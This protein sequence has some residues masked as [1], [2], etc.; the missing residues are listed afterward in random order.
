MEEIPRKVIVRAPARLHFGFLDL[1]GDVGRIY[2]SV[3]VAI[4]S[5]NVVLEASLD[6]KLNVTGEGK[7]TVAGYARSFLKKFDVGQGAR[8]Q[9]KSS[10]PRHAGLGS[11]TQLALATGLALSKLYNVRTSVEDLSL[12]M[13]R[14]VVSAIGIYAFK[15][16]GFIVEGGHKVGETKAVPPLLF[17]HDFPKNWLFVVGVPSI[18]RGPGEREETKHFVKPPLMSKEDVCE[19]SRVVLMRLLPA[20]LEK[21]V[22]SFG[23][24]ITELDS[25]VGDYWKPVQGGRFCDPVV[26]RGVE[27]LLDSGAYG[28]GQSSWGP[29]FYGLVRGE[30]E[31]IEL[32]QVLQRFLFEEGGGTAFH[33][34]ANNSGATA[35]VEGQLVK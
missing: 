28:A 19:I 3:G 35:R 32:E 1:R 22:D 31:A 30:A 15:T 12:L 8:L 18:F 29:T 9:I 34:R 7:T 6:K 20:L 24:A 11:T 33:A 5:P 16:G 17:H 21:D 4:E 25:K 27:L 26:E 23:R 10:I 2:G 13:E 14:G